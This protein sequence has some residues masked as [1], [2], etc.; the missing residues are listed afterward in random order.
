[1]EERTDDMESE[2]LDT[3]PAVI[4]N[5]SIFGKKTKQGSQ[6]NDSLFP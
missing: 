3:M 4:K 1:M 6:I 2:G 5:T